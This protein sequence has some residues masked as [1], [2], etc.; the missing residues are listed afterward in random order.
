VVIWYTYFVVIWY[1]Y[2][3]VNWYI[4]WLFGIPILWLFG[5]PIL[6]LIGIFCG[7][8]V[9]FVVIW[10]ILCRYLVYLS[11]FGIKHLATLSKGHSVPLAALGGSILLVCFL[12]FNGGSQVRPQEPILRL[13]NFQ[14]QRQRC[15][16]LERFFKVD[17]NIF[18]FKTH[19]ATCG[20]VK[21]FQGPMLWFF[22]NIFA[23]KIAKKCR[24]WSNYVL[25][26][27]RKNMELNIDFYEKHRKSTPVLSKTLYIDGLDAY[28]NYK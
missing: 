24:L 3:V 1:T 20:V 12:A 14:L 10:N 25:L 21:L 6:W 18:V 16:R 15:S 8:L 4:L 27:F 13:F 11:R 23:I 7:Y 5:T 28:T 17:E 9:Y 19:L 22:K 26:V 2:F